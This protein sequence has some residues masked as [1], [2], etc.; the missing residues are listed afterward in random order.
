M[1]PGRRLADLGTALGLR[2]DAA[3]PSDR[4]ARPLDNMLLRTSAAI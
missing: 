4:Q 2:S 1:D 3:L